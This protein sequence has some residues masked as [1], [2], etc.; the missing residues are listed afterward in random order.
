MAT[1]YGAQT[2]RARSDRS[3]RSEA[4]LARY[5]EALFRGER[6]E[7]IGLFTIAA[8]VVLCVAPWIADTPDA[9]KEASRNELGVGIVVILL[10]IVRFSHYPGKWADAALLVL[11]AWMIASPWV[12][13]LRNTE[14]TESSRA[15]DVVVGI[16]LVLLAAISVLLL[17]M[18][19]RAGSRRE[20]AEAREHNRPT[21]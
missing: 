8:G 4:S 18:S 16:A 12:I 13:G 21:N 6:Q 15:V 11:G 17:R 5:K 20:T 1:T 3:G 2:S 7:L 10:G 9:A 19:R 14:V